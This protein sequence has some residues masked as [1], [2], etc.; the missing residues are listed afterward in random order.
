[1][2]LATYPATLPSPLFPKQNRPLITAWGERA[3]SAGDDKS[4]NFAVNAAHYPDAEGGQWV[5]EDRQTSGKEEL[6]AN[7][8]KGLEG[9]GQLIDTK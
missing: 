6:K 1:M 5:R 3:R 4:L 7:E 2:G 9:Q 8:I